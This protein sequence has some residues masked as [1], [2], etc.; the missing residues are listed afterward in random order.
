MEHMTIDHGVLEMALVGYEMQRSR[1]EAA[2]AEIQAELGVGGSRRSKAAGAAAPE[3]ASPGKR[4]FSAAAKRRMALAQKKRWAM[5][6]AKT[7]QARKV[8]PTAPTKG[9]RA[10]IPSAAKKPH[11]TAKVAKKVA[12]KP[13]AQKVI[14]RP[15]PKTGSPKKIAANLPKAKIEVP[16]VQVQTSAEPTSLTE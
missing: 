13:K 16:A 11:V 12:P 5:L 2:I 3:P 10:T 9:R 7:A 8:K 15:K 6:K 1:I 14:G 4:R